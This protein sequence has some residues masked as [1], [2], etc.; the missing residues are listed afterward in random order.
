MGGD[1]AE[2]FALFVFNI[3]KEVSGDIYLKTVLTRGHEICT[4]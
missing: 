2:L 3:D 4:F 1:V